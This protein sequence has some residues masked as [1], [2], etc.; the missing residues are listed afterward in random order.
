MA[1]E[2]ETLVE[3][4]ELFATRDIGGDYTRLADSLGVAARRVEQPEALRDA[5]Q[6]GIDANRAGQSVLIEVITS[7]ET[8]FSNR[9][10]VNH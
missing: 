4:H 5:L 6:W 7:V 2:T 3:S 1:I 9:F 8:D 10:S